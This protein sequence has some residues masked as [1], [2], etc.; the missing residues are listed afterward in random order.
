MQERVRL[1]AVVVDFLP[2][3]A[4]GLTWRDLQQLAKQYSHTIEDVTAQKMVEAAD[5]DGTGAVTAHEFAA[6]AQAAR[7]G[8][9]WGKLRRSIIGPR[10]SEE[11]EDENDQEGVEPTVPPPVEPSAP[12]KL[13]ALPAPAAPSAM[14]P[15]NPF[16]RLDHT[17]RY[18]TAPAELAGAVDR[19]AQEARDAALAAELQITEARHARATSRGR[20]GDR[21]GDSWGAAYGSAPAPGAQVASSAWYARHILE[22]PWGTCGVW[23]VC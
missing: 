19:R 17:P 21:G 7:E 18:G 13:P 9:S 16:A 3:D 22:R 10:A 15:S 4:V 1:R 11:D 6:A 14:P 2:R 5:D 12:V 20:M 8:S 23:R